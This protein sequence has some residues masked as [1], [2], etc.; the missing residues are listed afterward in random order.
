MAVPTKLI[1]TSQGF[2]DA[3]GNVVANG[4]LSLTLSQAAEV[5]ASGGLVTTEPLYFVL[6]ANGKIT[7]TAIWFNDELTPSGT[8]YHAVLYASNQVRIIT[9]FGQWSIVGASADLSTMV[10]VAT[11]VS[12]ANALLLN[13]GTGV[14]QT[15]STG[16]VAITNNE[17]IGGTLGVTGLAS[18][19]NLE[20]IRFADQFSGAD[21]AAKVN[22]ADADLGA[23]KG[24]IW[25]N[26]SAGTSATTA[27]TL[28]DDHTLRFVQEGTYATTQAITL[29]NRSAIV[30]DNIFS[31]LINYT[32]SSYAVEINTVTQPILE[33]GIQLA[34]T[35]LGAV[36]LRNT[37]NSFET[38]AKGKIYITATWTS[39]QLGLLFQATTAT[40]SVYHCKVE[41]Y[42]ENVAIPIRLISTVNNQGPNA[43]WIY[44]ESS[45]HTVAFDI[46][47]ATDGVFQGTVLGCHGLTGGT[48][49]R[50]G[51]GSGGYG[52]ANCVFA[53]FSSE[54]GGTSTT[55]SVASGAGL[56]VGCGNSV[57]IGQSNDSTGLTDANTT[58]TFC[59]LQNG[60]T[61]W[62]ALIADNIL[63]FGGARSAASAAIKR[64]GTA[65][66]ARLGDDSLYT[67]FVATQ[68]TS[69]V[70]TGTAP[71]V[72]TS[73][74]PVANLTVQRG[75]AAS[76][77]SGTA[78]AVVNTVDL[79]AQNASITTTNINSGT[80]AAGQYIVTWYAKV[81]TA[82]GVSSTLGPLTLGWTD[83][84]AVGLAI[85]ATAATAGG[86]TATSSTG[87]TTTTVLLGIPVLLNVKASTNVTYAMAYASNAA[88][89]MQ[90]NLHIKLEAL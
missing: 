51:S 62:H 86:G 39:G 75:A 41:V 6:D 20:N 10:P 83:P 44:L 36:R 27:L 24:E 74:T 87:N 65:L 38:R 46:A 26:Q 66:E 50:L 61:L 13:P 5:T 4:L 85:T 2:Q 88:N 73:T 67:N 71:L 52:V 40:S 59:W 25:I 90:Y 15:V 35:A 84:D 22:A 58:S 34:T 28:S 12:T 77:A 63:A 23:T 81:T 79:T 76:G 7:S 32:G 54:Q 49:F 8:T 43:N 9:D 30:C 60:G 42:A 18:F 64:N 57:A 48:T 89:A 78:E 31:T 72:V 80:L 70:A 3:K 19:K 45:G 1:S 29:G 14:T 55:I 33:I 11:N 53:P 21:W 16:N 68:L 69:N 82:A 47:D 17:T 56:T 37:G